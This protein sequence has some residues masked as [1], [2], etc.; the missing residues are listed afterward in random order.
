[1]NNFS[2]NLKTFIRFAQKS[3]TVDAPTGA[4]R[5]EYNPLEIEG[6][7]HWAQMESVKYS[8]HYAQT[9]ALDG[10]TTVFTL[11]AFDLRNV[12]LSFPSETLY[13]GVT[14]PNPGGFD[15][16]PGDWEHKYK[17]YRILGVQPEKEHL[18]KFFCM[19]EEF[20]D[21]FSEGVPI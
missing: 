16:G 12:L 17:Y 13:I 2:K 3:T 21:Y 4:T 8:R 18:I 19:E 7:E 1:M 6:F 15:P 11:R 5:R 20:T 10:V 14:L 9:Q